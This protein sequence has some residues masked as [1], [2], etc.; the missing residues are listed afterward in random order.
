MSL[1]LRSALFLA[2]CLPVFAQIPNIGP[3]G[4]TTRAQTGFQ[5]TEGPASDL[6]G[7]IYFSDVQRSRIHKIDTQGVLTTFLDNQPSVN[8]L[9][10][11][12]RGRLIACQTGRIVAIDIATKEV[13]VL[14]SQF[15]NTN[16]QG[17]ND[18]A[19]DRQ[20]NVYF[21]DRTGGSVFFIAADRTV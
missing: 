7:S 10:F 16:F 8:G 14:A 9:M 4:Q 20:G 1:A 12:P 3:V 2:L 21:S 19:V 11:D 6:Q 15:E 18:L 13:T 5:F 17:P